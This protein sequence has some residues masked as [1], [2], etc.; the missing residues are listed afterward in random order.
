MPIPSRM[1]KRPDSGRR[2]KNSLSWEAR[3]GGEESLGKFKPPA[4]PSQI[5][6]WFCFKKSI[7]LFKKMNWYTIGT[8]WL[9]GW[10]GRLSKGLARMACEK[11]TIIRPQTLLYVGTNTANSTLPGKK[12]ALRKLV[13]GALL[14]CNIPLYNDPNLDSTAKQYCAPSLFFFANGLYRCLQKFV[15]YHLR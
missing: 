7:P 9:S 2:G 12:M 1:H 3:R 13:H 11:K 15:F 6:T 8:Q 14:Y 10:G 4:V 5:R